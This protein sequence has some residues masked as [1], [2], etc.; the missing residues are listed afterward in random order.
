MKQ[1]AAMQYE[2]PRNSRTNIILPTYLSIHQNKPIFNKR[3][4]L[5]E[6]SEQ[7]M[8]VLDGINHSGKGHVWFAGQGI[9]KSWE[10]K[11][12]MLSPA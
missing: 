2:P 11:R 10:M 4:L 7:L 9:Q 8:A 1:S 12:Q 5:W 6:N 3:S